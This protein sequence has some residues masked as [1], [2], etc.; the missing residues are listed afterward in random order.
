[1]Q[2]LCAFCHKNFSI[3]N[4]AHNRGKGLS[5]QIQCPHC[6]AWLG[7]NR[8][9]T[10]GKIIGFYTAAGAGIAGYMIDNVNHIVT[11]I[12][13]LSLILVGVTHIMDHLLLI[14]APEEDDATND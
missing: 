3:A 8:L 14:E 4:V 2:L 12:I 13:I 6:N 7:R 5:A 1:M 10:I 9:L 11:P